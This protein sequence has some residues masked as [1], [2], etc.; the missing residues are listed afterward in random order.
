MLSA[1]HRAHP[2]DASLVADDLDGAFLVADFDRLDG[3]QY[4]AVL[5]DRLQVVADLDDDGVAVLGQAAHVDA[6]SPT[7][8]PEVPLVSDRHPDVRGAEALGGDVC[9]NV[10]HGRVGD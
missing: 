2:M 8:G 4:V 5:V 10:G 6:D 1:W 7:D 3:E 9:D